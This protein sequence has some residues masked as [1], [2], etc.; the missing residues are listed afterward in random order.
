MCAHAEKKLKNDRYQFCN[1]QVESQVSSAYQ[2]VTTY[3]ITVY[4]NPR[5]NRKKK[6]NKDA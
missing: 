4:Y 5:C 6:E 3:F 2:L 1:L